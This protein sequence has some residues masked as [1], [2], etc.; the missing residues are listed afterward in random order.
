[1]EVRH[2]LQITFGIILLLGIFTFALNKP[3]ITGHVLININRQSLDI[4]IDESQNFLLSSDSVEP[5]VITSFK[6]SG[7]ITGDGQVKVY[8]DTG[9]GQRVLVFENIQKKEIYLPEYGEMPTFFTHLHLPQKVP[10]IEKVP[11]LELNVLFE[12]VFR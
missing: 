2:K 10:E 7:N 3:S 1:M 12:K 11:P 4:V 8:I 9:R 5:F 6:V